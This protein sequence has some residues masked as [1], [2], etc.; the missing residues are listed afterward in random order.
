[1]TMRDIQSMA[2]LIAHQH[3]WDDDM[4]EVDVPKF[5]TNTHAELSEAW[6]E[7]RSGV[8]LLEVRYEGEDGKP[9]G[10]PVEL[11]DVIIRI[12]DTV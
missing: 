10:F 6:E 8:D 11:A 1:M 4:K 12:A 7:Y 9:E 2:N 5:L 3:G